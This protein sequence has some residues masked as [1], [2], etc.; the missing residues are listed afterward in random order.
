MKT[1]ILLFLSVWVMSQSGCGTSP[2][3]HNV[4]QRTLLAV[5]T[6]VDLGMKVAAQLVKD[7][8][9][10]RTQYEATIAP[11][12]NKYIAAFSFAV[13]AVKNN[14]SAPAPDDVIALSA[15]LLRIINSY[16]Q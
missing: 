5:G 10:T 12:F 1:A 11:A 4:E 13:E 15:D 16:R 8:F 14:T 6:S 3:V 7:G 2:A 9:I